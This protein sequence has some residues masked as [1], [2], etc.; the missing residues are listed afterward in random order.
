[1]LTGNERPLLTAV[2]DAGVIISQLQDPQPSAVST[3]HQEILRHV[4]STLGYEIPPRQ[5]ELLPSSSL[6]SALLTAVSTPALTSRSHQS[7]DGVKLPDG[8]PAASF[9][10]GVNG[11]SLPAVPVSEQL[12]RVPASVLFNATAL[13]VRDRLLAQMK[14]TEEECERVVSVVV[15]HTRH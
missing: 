7:L 13:C 6:P 9:R 4:R 15:I 1:M 11:N 10:V 2:S 8:R 12:K 3:L 14:A 5:S